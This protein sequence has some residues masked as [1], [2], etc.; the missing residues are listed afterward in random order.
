MPT[1]RKKTYGDRQ[2]E[3]AR[4]KREAERAKFLKQTTEKKPVEE[5]KQS[6][7]G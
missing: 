2:S 5:S 1:N 3:A 6:N 7:E 4:A